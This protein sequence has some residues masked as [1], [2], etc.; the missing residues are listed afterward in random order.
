[1]G[2]QGGRGWVCDVDPMREGV[3]VGLGLEEGLGWSVMGTQGG[4][5]WVCDLD[6]RREGVGAGLGL[7]EV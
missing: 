1:M 2:S 3:G 6:P 5:G 4:M 7:K